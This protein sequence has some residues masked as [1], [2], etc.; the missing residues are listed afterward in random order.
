M[1]KAAWLTT[2]GYKARQSKDGHSELSSLQKK[3]K[4]KKTLVVLEYYEY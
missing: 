2:S 3:E 4:K 1:D